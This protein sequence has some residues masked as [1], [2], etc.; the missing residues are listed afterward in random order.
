MKPFRLD[1]GYQ[2]KQIKQLSYECEQ[3]LNPVSWLETEVTLRN[4]V[5]G[6]GRGKDTAQ[7]EDYTSKST[8]SQAGSLAENKL[9]S[10]VSLPAQ[11]PLL[12]DLTGLSKDEIQILTDVFR[13]QEQFEVETKD[14]I[15]NIKVALEKYETLSTEFA[16]QKSTGYI[17]LRL[18]QLCYH[19]KFPDG[20]GRVCC[21]CEK[22]VCHKCG[23]FARPRWDPK[24]SKSIRGKWR[25]AHCQLRR[26]MMCKTGTW[27]HGDD[28]VD[29]F[30]SS[31]STIKPRQD[32]EEAA[33]KLIDDTLTDIS[34]DVF[35][36]AVETEGHPKGIQN[37]VNR[38]S[39]R[40]R[41][42]PTGYSCEYRDEDASGDTEQFENERKMR[43]KK[44]LDRKFRRRSVLRNRSEY[45]HE[46]PEIIV[47]SPEEP[48]R[49]SARTRALSA[50]SVNNKK[51]SESNVRRKP[52]R[53]EDG[54]CED[55]KNE[56]VTEKRNDSHHKIQR[57]DAVCYS[58]SSNS[59]TSESKVEV[60]A[61]DT[62]KTL[63][64]NDYNAK[65]LSATEKKNKF[66]SVSLTPTRVRTLDVT[67]VFR[68][69]TYDVPMVRGNDLLAPDTSPNKC[70]RI[71]LP[72][73]QDLG[74]AAQKAKGD[75]V[76]VPP[77]NPHEVI[78]HRNKD[79]ISC[80][81]RG[82]GMRVIGGKR[83]KRGRMGAYVTNVEERGPAD[84]QGNIREGDQI[85]TWDGQSLVDVTFEE[86]QEIMDHSGNIVQIVIWHRPVT[87]EET[88]APTAASRREKFQRADTT[89]MELTQSTNKEFESFGIRRK[90]R[91]LPKTPL[92]IKKDTT[93]LITGRLQMKLNY[94]PEQM[95]LLVTLIKVVNLVPPEK[96]ERKVPNP[97]AML[98][99]LPKRSESQVFETTTILECSSPEWNETFTFVEIPPSRFKS[100]TL[101][102]T[103][104]SFNK[105]ADDDFIGE[106]L[107]DLY[108]APMNNQLIWYDLEDHDENSSPLPERQQFFPDN[109]PMSS[110]ST[111]TSRGG[112][113]CRGSPSP[114]N[115]SPA[116]SFS[117][118]SVSGMTNYEKKKHLLTHTKK[119][120]A[121][122]KLDAP[123]GRISPLHSPA[124]SED[125][126]I[127]QPGIHRNSLSK[128]VK[129]KMSQA[130]MKVSASLAVSDCKDSNES[131]PSVKLSESDL[132]TLIVEDFSPPVNR[133]VSAG[134]VHTLDIKDYLLPSSLQNR[135]SAPQLGDLATPLS[136]ATS[137]ASLHA[138]TPSGEILRSTQ[139]SPLFQR[140]DNVP[141][142]PCQ[143]PGQ[144]EA[145]QPGDETKGCM[146]LGFIVTKGQLEI[147]VITAQ[148]LRRSDKSLPQETYVKTYIMQGNKTMQKKK[149][150]VNKEGGNPN[151]RE[152]IKYSA[153]NALGR[154][155]KINI[156]EKQ[157]TFD[158]K[159]CLGEIVVKLE[160]LD[161]S[162]H[163]VGWYQLFSPGATDMSS[164]EAFSHW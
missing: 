62:P 88:V 157:K 105:S 156:W 91:I 33:S 1:A 50:S 26:E 140:F 63:E 119:S 126:Y 132:R 7:S 86:A 128:K 42:L 58:S 138:E 152:K 6:F 31:E 142:F 43:R 16:T 57:Q 134:N 98:H 9:E 8:V 67:P 30:E 108:D 89:D 18:C 46:I 69:S 65:P 23:S 4:N 143:G 14:R 74:L 38:R 55:K 3:R 84:L 92:E 12:P 93:R 94:K 164:D 102:V 124:S 100:L 114:I 13:R 39:H 97:V 159:V 96:P 110:A 60:P 22:R 135:G 147:S 36:S 11:N 5:F 95:K 116:H 53:K 122:D 77:S 34:S 29:Y 32:F 160:N 81:T 71:T 111:E 37:T 68:S 106:V 127:V 45:D 76:N 52:I 10:S 125:S 149:T 72:L 51:Q 120:P 148:G 80:R 103:L 35:R 145:V 101:E 61:S 44:R 85:I 139:T 117:H 118:K 161:L 2:A 131:L 56:K 151:Y 54:V 15:R 66:R 109:S 78:L 82:L 162:K 41:S 64:P 90:K 25:C 28:T 154:H 144:I 115:R 59:L 40:A 79:D 113:P 21:D 83:G 70:R 47:N 75:Q 123:F 136:Q 87:E 146:K 141:E 133:S 158:K 137:I 27:Y 24:R 155:L 153:C 150:S 49:R 107:M 17:D 48:Y 19:V 73:C 20:I 129:R 99:L 130:V 163:T 121:R 104:W 112:T